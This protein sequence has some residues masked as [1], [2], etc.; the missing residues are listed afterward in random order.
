LTE[1]NQALKPFKEKRERVFEVARETGY[2]IKLNEE[3][4][5]FLREMQDKVEPEIYD[6]YALA[7]LMA[8]MS[9]GEG[10]ETPYIDFPDK[11]LENFFNK[12]YLEYVLKRKPVVYSV[13]DT[14]PNIFHTLTDSRPREITIYK[15]NP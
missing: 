3:I 10:N 5:S 6:K 14:K 11:S 4:T 15:I 1:I 8:G 9:I 2:I 12:K 7:C 13:L